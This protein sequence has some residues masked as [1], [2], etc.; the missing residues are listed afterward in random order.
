M[1]KRI[2]SLSLFIACFSSLCFSTRADRTIE[3]VN[4]DLNRLAG[5]KRKITGPQREEAEHKKKAL[6]Q[7]F[8]TCLALQHNFFQTVEKIK[9]SQYKFEKLVERLL[10]FR[11]DDTE[12]FS[13]SK[14]GVGD[15]VGIE[16]D[17]TKVWDNPND[18]LAGVN[19][20][21]TRYREACQLLQM[22][23]KL[24]PDFIIAYYDKDKNIALKCIASMLRLKKHIHEEYTKLEGLFLTVKTYALVLPILYKTHKLVDLPETN[25][26]RS[27]IKQF[28]SEAAPKI[29]S[30]VTGIPYK[31]V[32][33]ALLS[34]YKAQQDFLLSVYTWTK[35]DS[36]IQLYFQWEFMGLIKDY[37]KPVIRNLITI[38][39][40]GQ[41]LPKNL[42]PIE[43]DAE[44]TAAE[45]HAAELLAEEEDTAEGAGPTLVARAAPVDFV[46]GAAP[47]D[48]P[49]ET[50][51]FDLGGYIEVRE[52][53]HTV[54]LFKVPREDFRVFDF[55]DHS[56]VERWFTDPDEALREDN[57]TCDP[58][59]FPWKI[60]IHNFSREVDPLIFNHGRKQLWGRQKGFRAPY[61]QIEIP[62]ELIMNEGKRGKGIFTY[63]FF[64]ELDATR[65]PTGRYILFHRYFNQISDMAEL[66]KRF[67][68]GDWVRLEDEE[69]DL[70]IR[71]LG[72][73]TAAKSKQ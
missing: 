58:R 14:S 69:M 41:P 21:D 59:L 73:A 56:R 26:M 24:I 37:P 2:L 3:D 53:D 25:F 11:R 45:V 4:S 49:V 61:V 33:C 8:A 63:T 60:L 20:E 34:Q 15:G 51:T 5:F 70:A 46:S 47:V 66:R 42:V 29:V 17:L 19:M 16:F 44:D 62:G 71:A 54:R 12:T 18:F 10:K 38:L 6:Q 13:L 55:D 30:E 7:H 9:V 43:L 32:F 72:A 50:G 31:E 48:A 57:Y 28:P 39:H 64:N 22:P 35:Q 52:V 40:I 23:I 1:F 65:K 36:E 68:L 67:M 27:A